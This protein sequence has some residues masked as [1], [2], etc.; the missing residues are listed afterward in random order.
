[1]ANYTISIQNLYEKFGEKLSHGYITTEE[2]GSGGHYYDFHNRDGNLACC[3]GETVAV[4]SKENG[5]YKLLSDCALEEVPF[6]LNAEEFGIAAVS[7]VIQV[8]CEAV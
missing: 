8:E 6:T 7:R 4:L 5:V 1:M 3:D 2:N